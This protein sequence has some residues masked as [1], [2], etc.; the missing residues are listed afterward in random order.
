MRLSIVYLPI[1]LLAH[2]G[3]QYAVVTYTVHEIAPEGLKFPPLSLDDCKELSATLVSHLDPHFWTLVLFHMTGF[4][5]L[6]TW[7]IPGTFFFNL[8]GG[9]LFGVKLGWVLCVLMNTLGAT[10][11]F[12]L[13][14]VF[15]G[16][17]VHMP[18]FKSK[19][20]AIEK[21][22]SEH[23]ENLFFYLTFLRLFPGSPNWVMNITFPHLG[24]PTT[25]VLLSVFFGLMPWNYIT[26][27][28]G[29]VLATIK[30]KDD[31]MKT[32]TYV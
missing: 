28:A 7:C 5:F 26:V 19:F 23:K 10:F 31:I 13:S 25:Y 6:Q 18:F 14:K 20:E 24:V 21:K 16:S 8:L 30:S 22:V 27:Q 29:S 32:E 11:C 1:V 17:V 2:I 4:F 9:S 15:G 12:L 3:I